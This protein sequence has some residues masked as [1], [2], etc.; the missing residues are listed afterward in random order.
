MCIRD[1]S[2][3]STGDFIS[4]EIVSNNNSTSHNR[5]LFGSSKKYTERYKEK[6]TRTMWWRFRPILTYQ[7]QRMVCSSP[8]AVT[9]AVGSATFT[10][11]LG[12]PT[13]INA[14]AQKRREAIAWN[15]SFP[16]GL[17]WTEPKD[18]NSFCFSRSFILGLFG[19]SAIAEQF[20]CCFAFGLI[21]PV[22]VALMAKD[23]MKRSFDVHT[24]F[25]VPTRE[26]KKQVGPPSMSAIRFGTGVASTIINF[27][28][29]DAQKVDR[30]I[31][32][33]SKAMKQK[34]LQQQQREQ[35][36]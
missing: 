2:T 23:I 27:K 29:I 10:I 32:I 25:L 4:R 33:L 1:R 9:Y 16:E 34:E 36:Q 28:L 18:P 20:G 19:L 13:C 30:E 26:N 3:Q 7:G 24:W 14:F 6:E 22:P 12:I 15:K 21:W 5:S 8:K 17:W 31:S 35:G 11:A